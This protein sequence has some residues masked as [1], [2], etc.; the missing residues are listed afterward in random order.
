[1]TMA[2][3]QHG[4]ETKRRTGHQAGATPVHRE[5]QVERVAELLWLQRGTA[6]PWNAQDPAVQDSYRQ[7][8]AILRAAVLAETMPPPAS[9]RSRQEVIRL[10][11][12][13]AEER[14]RMAGQVERL[15]EYINQLELRVSSD[16]PHVMRAA[17]GIQSGDLDT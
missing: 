8:A 2:H 6:A 14:T 15:Q 7:L 9:D 3:A 1:M 12:D 11:A 13:I 5:T 16:T 10:R 4:S 17:A